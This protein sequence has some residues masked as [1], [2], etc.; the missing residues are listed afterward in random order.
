LSAMWP[1][2]AMMSANDVMQNEGRLEWQLT[3]AL[4]N[5]SSEQPKSV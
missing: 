5:R 4:S 3:G 1:N 2:P